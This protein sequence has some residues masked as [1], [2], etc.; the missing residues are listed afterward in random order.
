MFSNGLGA[1]DRYHCRTRGLHPLPSRSCTGSVAR[2]CR[3]CRPFSAAGDRAFCLYLCND[4]ALRTP[5]RGGLLQT[6]LLRRTR[7]PTCHT[8]AR[9][10][11]FRLRSPSGGYP[12]LGSLSSSGR[13]PTGI[14]ALRMN[15][16]RTSFRRDGAA[17]ERCTLTRADGMRFFSAALQHAGVGQTGRRAGGGQR[18]VLLALPYRGCSAMRASSPPRGSCHCVRSDA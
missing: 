14:S 17:L 10:H 18:A 15:G 7:A 6:K 13:P 1:A 5:S 12:H 4:S 3:W 2:A 11:F 9:L 16:G 8:V